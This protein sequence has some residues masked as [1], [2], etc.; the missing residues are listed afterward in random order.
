MNARYVNNRPGEGSNYRMIAI[1]N[2]QGKTWSQMSVDRNFAYSN[3]IDARLTRLPIKNEDGKSRILH[4]KNKHPDGTRE[5]LTVRM[6]YNEGET[7]LL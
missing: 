5:Q 2:D 6:S 4:S 1:S 3:P 7:W